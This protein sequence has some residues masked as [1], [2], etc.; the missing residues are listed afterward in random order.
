M[1]VSMQT[2]LTTACLTCAILVGAPPAGAQVR[3]QLWN[4]AIIGGA[5]G[6][7]VG[8]ALTQYTSDSELGVREY[9]YGAL[10]FGAIG[11]GAGIGIDALLFRNQPRPAGKPPRVLI[12]P[13]VW[14]NTRAVA[15]KWRW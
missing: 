9:G 4:G 6:A 8:I 3:D 11:A 2:W 10:V 15:V 12:A 1:I 14:R 7:G 5:I 13:A